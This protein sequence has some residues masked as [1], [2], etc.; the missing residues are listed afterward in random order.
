[1]NDSNAACG[2]EPD[3]CNLLGIHNDT[4]QSLSSDS[5]WNLSG[6]ATRSEYWAFVAPFLIGVFFITIVIAIDI[7]KSAIDNR[8]HG[9]GPL[10]I[11]TVV[12]VL[13][14]KLLTFPITVRRLHDRN[15]S[16]WFL[17]AFLIIPFGEWAKFI[18]V[19]CLNGTVGPNEFGPDPKNR[20]S[21]QQ[22]LQQLIDAVTIGCQPRIAERSSVEIAETQGG[23]HCVRRGI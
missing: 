23:W 1:M 9:W 19:G 15:M 6:R 21:I 5:F 16:G 14:C 18:I 7:V 8:D 10:L 3:V 4:K 20:R 13:V 17:L 11:F 22:Q 2:Q 12:C